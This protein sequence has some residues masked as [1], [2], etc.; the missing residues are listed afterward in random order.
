[1]TTSFQESDERV[2]Y[3]SVGRRDTDGDKWHIRRKIWPCECRGEEF[4]HNGR[5]CDEEKDMRARR[6]W[7]DCNIGRDRHMARRVD[8]RS[9]TRS[10]RR[11]YIE[12]PSVRA[13][14]WEF[15]WLCMLKLWVIEISTYYYKIW[16]DDYQH[17]PEAPA[18]SVSRYE[19]IFR[20]PT[21]FSVGGYSAY[22]RVGMRAP[23]SYSQESG[24]EDENYIASYTEW[25]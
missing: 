14:W 13:L 21:I 11:S 25:R 6:L 20:A 1:M 8:Y 5:G 23:S 10:V 2:E 18:S 4:L 22:Q 12:L 15:I 17:A 9:L 7:G 24:T 19:S 16:G 3:R